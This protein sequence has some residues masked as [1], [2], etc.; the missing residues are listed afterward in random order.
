MKRGTA[1]CIV[2]SVIFAALAVFTYFYEARSTGLLPVIT[3][4]LRAYTIPFAIISV[5]LASCSIFIQISR[6]GKGNR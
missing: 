2:L 3:Y 1:V 4:P 6:Q 5:I